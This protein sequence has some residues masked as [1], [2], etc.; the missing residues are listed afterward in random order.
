MAYR[1]FDF[2]GNEITQYDLQEKGSLCISGAEF[3]KVF[4]DKHRDL[5]LTIN[6][7][8]YRN[9][10]SPDLINTKNRSLADHKTQDTSFFLSKERYGIN[11]QYAVSFN[12]KD[13]LRYTSLYPG[14]DIYFWVDWQAVKLLDKNW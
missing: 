14:I 9:K 13:Y 5:C 12:E 7:D 1:M 4:I 2:K 6:T 8:K 10:Y 3:E 11:P